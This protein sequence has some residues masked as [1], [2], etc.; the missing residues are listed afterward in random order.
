MKDCGP[1]FF[2]RFSKIFNLLWLNQCVWFCEVLI[3]LNDFIGKLTYK[4]RPCKK[5]E[6]ACSNKKCIPMD[7]Q[8]DQL[9]DCG[10]GSDE[11]GCKISEFV[12]CLRKCRHTHIQF[13]LRHDWNFL[14]CCEKKLFLKMC[15]SNAFLKSLHQN[16][17]RTSLKLVSESKRWE[18]L[19][20]QLSTLKV[21][22]ENSIFNYILWCQQ[23]NLSPL[24]FYF[25]KI[26][27]IFLNFT[28]SDIW[29]ND[30]KNLNNLLN[31]LKF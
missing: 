20:L 3:I 1:M 18:R 12:F 31:V 15:L 8:C 10:D 19:I 9:D 6:F 28:N 21:E 27:L 16:K 26:S 22:V 24:V 14:Y 2:I 25:I 17:F 30:G 29:L 7:L 4:A 5:D 23:R 11:Q 13:L